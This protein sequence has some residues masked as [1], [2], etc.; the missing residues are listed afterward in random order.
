MLELKS[1]IQYSVLSVK[2]Q[3]VTVAGET[4]FSSK[5]RVCIQT[6]Y[7]HKLRYNII[8]STTDCQMLIYFGELKSLIYCEET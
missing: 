7:W 5:T 8:P 1:Q 3:S 2:M 4:V 6:V